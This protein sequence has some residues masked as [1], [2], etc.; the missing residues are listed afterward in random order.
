[1]PRDEELSLREVT[2]TALAEDVRPPRERLPIDKI[3]A[4]PPSGPRA[5]N[6]ALLLSR[7]EAKKDAG[8]QLL[9]TDSIMPNPNQPRIFFDSKKMKSLTA[10][11]KEVGQKIPIVLERVPTLPKLLI[12]DGERRWRACT[13]LGRPV[14]AII[15]PETNPTARLLDSAI[16]NFGREGHTAFEV[17]LTLKRLK[18]LGLIN[19]RLAAAFT[20]S[21]G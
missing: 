10:S 8:E 21:V 14:K 16:A 4:S 6:M 1:M 5:A 3:S 17:A 11:I 15:R 20:K 13:A 12:V 2:E 9:P 7:V 18:D 19:E